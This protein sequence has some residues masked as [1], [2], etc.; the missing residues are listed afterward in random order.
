IDDA[1]HQ[2]ARRRQALG[3]GEA[4]GPGV[5]SDQ[6]R[7]GAADVDGRED[8]A[9]SC[10]VVRG[11]RRACP[12]TSSLCFIAILRRYTSSLYLGTGGPATG[13]GPVPARRWICGASRTTMRFET[14]KAIRQ[15]LERE[16]PMRTRRLSERLLPVLMGGVAAIAFQAAGPAA[17]Q[18]A[19]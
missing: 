3:L 15:H 9:C 2:V 6:I 1:L 8:H 7:E 10:A 5:E 19:P 17:A 13:V 12:Y 14:R 16:V 11:R 18:T 4:A